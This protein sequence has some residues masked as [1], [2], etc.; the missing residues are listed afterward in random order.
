MGCQQSTSAVSTED[1]GTQSFTCARRSRSLSEFRKGLQKPS[2]FDVELEKRPG[3]RLGVS[4]GRTGKGAVIVSLKAGIFADYN[5][6]AKQERKVRVG[7]IIVSVNG[8]T[9]Y[10]ELSEELKKIGDLRMVISPTPPKGANASWFEDIER[11][12]KS[13][14]LHSDGNS[15]AVK[16]KSDNPK[17]Q[18]AFSSLP[19]MKASECECDQ[20][21]ICLEDVDPD[22][23]VVELPCGHAFHVPCGGRWLGETGRHA[24]GKEQCCPLCCQSVV[25]EVSVRKARTEPLR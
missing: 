14:D 6:F 19:V 12:G 16:V 2:D 17:D 15:F 20:C 24:K 1:I 10:W 4:L 21:A 23:P 22:D 18:F 13:T 7:F 5:V 11:M 8:K 3:D 25:S 9:D